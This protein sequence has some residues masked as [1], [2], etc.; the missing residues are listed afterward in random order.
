MEPHLENER[1]LTRL[2]PPLSQ[3]KERWRVLSLPCARSARGR[4]GEGA[5]S[6]SRVALLALPDVRQRLFEMGAETAPGTPGELDAY[7]KSEL[8]KWAKVVRDVGIK[9]E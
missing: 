2:L 1:E 6:C 7:V 8:E 9:V 4:A 3:G 5:S